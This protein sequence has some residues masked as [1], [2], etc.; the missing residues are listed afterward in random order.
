MITAAVV[1]A[2]DTVLD[3]NNDK[4][5]IMTNAVILIV[6]VLFCYNANFNPWI[7]LIN[8]AFIHTI[9]ESELKAAKEDA[10]VENAEIILYDMLT[11]LAERMNATNAISVLSQSLSEE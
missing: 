7:I 4:I 2:E 1:C 8:I 9:A 10:I 6:I 5:G 11:H 3:T